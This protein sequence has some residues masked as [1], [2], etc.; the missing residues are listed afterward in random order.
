MKINLKYLTT[1]LDCI[2]F[3]NEKIF[4]N[5]IFINQFQKIQVPYFNYCK[6]FQIFYST[7]HKL[8]GMHYFE[9]IFFCLC[10][11]FSQF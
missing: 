11:K 8:N 1:Y 4:L 7:Y 5:A 6:V 10:Q 3:C 2:K 9:S